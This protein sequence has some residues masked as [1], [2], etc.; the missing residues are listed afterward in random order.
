MNIQSPDGGGQ[1]NAQDVF[2]PIM[3]AMPQLVRCNAFS[4]SVYRGAGGGDRREPRSRD[5]CRAGSVR[6][7][8]AMLLRP[9]VEIGGPGRS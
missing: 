3:A 7:M 6:V 1:P 9:F 8:F 5:C 4:S 2:V